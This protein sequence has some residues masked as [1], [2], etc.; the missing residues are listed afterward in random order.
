MIALIASIL[1]VAW[2]LLAYAMM[3]GH[4]SVEE[5]NLLVPIGLD[6]LLLLVGIVAVIQAIRHR[7]PWT[8]A[9][10]ICTTP[11]F[12]GAAGMLEGYRTFGFFVPS[13]LII[14]LVIREQLK[15]LKAS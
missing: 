10:L 5:G 4:I 9:L 12:H 11:L 8:L 13:T 14:V 15:R 3:R 2:M 1:S 7:Y 6:L